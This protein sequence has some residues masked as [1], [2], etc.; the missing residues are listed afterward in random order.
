MFP[1]E[2]FFALRNLEKGSGRKGS[3]KFFIV[4]VYSKN[5]YTLESVRMSVWPFTR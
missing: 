5:E 3:A 4:F 2:P 1:T